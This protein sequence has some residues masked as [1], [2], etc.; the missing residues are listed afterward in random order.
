MV[1]AETLQ[2]ALGPL[3]LSRSELGELLTAAQQSVPQGIRIRSPSVADAL[4]FSMHA[5]PWHPRAFVVD[6]DDRVSRRLHYAAGQY[7]IQ[8]VASLMAV[9]LLDVQPGHRVCDLCAA[10]GGKSTAILEDLADSG[11]LL[12]N[13]VIHSR[14]GAL[15]F[16]LARHGSP[17]YVVSLLDPGQLSEWMGAVFDRVLV[18]APCSGQ[19][20]VAR[21]KQTTASFQ[22]RAIAHCAARQQRILEAA[23]QLVRPGGRLVYSTCTFSFAENEQ[24][25]AQLL[26]ANPDWQSVE[27]P[28]LA[29]WSSAA[30]AGCYRLWP[31]RDGCGGAF[32]AALERRIDATPFQGVPSRPLQPKLG[33]RS[34]PDEFSSW[35][36][37][38]EEHLL[39]SDHRMFGW[40]ET[41]WKALVPH[42][43]AGPEVTFRKKA[44]WFPAYGLAMRRDTNWRPN[45]RWKLDDQQARQYVEGQTLACPYQGWVL[46]TWR[47]QPLG[48]CKSDGRRAKNH[49]PKPA[50]ITVA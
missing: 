35:G 29:P 46:A 24:Q 8:D 31:H 7:Y 3:E 30:M 9:T 22:P 38:E 21:G 28:Q 37:I 4:G 20:L 44:T 6:R 15:Q 26:R 45:C 10:P 1:D 17:R 42:V 48:W 13:E 23:V 14:A 39:A 2:R 33:P 27:M 18:D 11:W 34:L 16:N 32:A 47:D 19:S 41:L 50:R 40:P 49:L 25:V 36:A 5:V 43:S 12:A